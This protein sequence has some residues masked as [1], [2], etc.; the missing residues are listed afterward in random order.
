MAGGELK[1]LTL[2]RRRLQR[3]FGLHAKVALVALTLLTIPW[4][5][6]SYVRGME[7][8][9]RDNQEQQ[10]AASA[11][12]IATALQDRPGLL[13]LHGPAPKINE[14]KRPP[15]NAQLPEGELIQAGPGPLPV[16]K[17]EKA[18]PGQA[19]VQPLLFIACAFA[20]LQAETV[21]INCGTTAPGLVVWTV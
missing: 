6:Y 1:P 2:V 21:G 17:A 7:K 19:T 15:D 4:V 16:E 14:I 8:L 11:R 12:A 3:L 13:V 20:A 5:G 10:V 18:E 9:L